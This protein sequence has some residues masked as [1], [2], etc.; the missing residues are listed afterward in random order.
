MSLPSS[1][2]NTIND[3]SS[4]S[5]KK[6]RIA[7]FYRRNY[8]ECYSPKTV[9]IELGEKYNT[10]KTYVYQLWKKEYLKRIGKALYQWNGRLTPKQVE[11]MLAE[12]EPVF[13]ALECIIKGGRGTAGISFPNQLP[14]LLDELGIDHAQRKCKWH[15]CNDDVLQVSFSS[16]KNPFNTL[17][18]VSLLTWLIAKFPDPFEICIT[19]FEINKDLVGITLK[20]IECIE[21]RA[22]LNWVNRVYNKSHGIRFESKWSG[23]K[24]I[25]HLDPYDALEV[26]SHTYLRPIIEKKNE[27]K[28]VPRIK[29]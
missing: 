18:L 1:D 13:H 28:P 11:E 19:N 21:V 20:G 24:L 15:P 14:D 7:N 5:T 12:K 16:T 3:I 22:F 8:R 2:K 17:E 29:S 27:R 9:S 10:V 26:L 25:G 4:S 23:N 6:D